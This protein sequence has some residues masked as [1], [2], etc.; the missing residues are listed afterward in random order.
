MSDAFADALRTV[1]RGRKS[2]PTIGN[3]FSNHWKNSEKFF[4]SLENWRKIFP[5]IGKFGA[6][7]PT[8]GKLFS[9]HWKIRVLAASQQVVK[10][11]KGKGKKKVRVYVVAGVVVGNN[12]KF[13]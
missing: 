4:Q 1:E 3:I 13:F 12:R 6:V 7:F 5:I 8:I 10:G 9:N 2:F 11:E